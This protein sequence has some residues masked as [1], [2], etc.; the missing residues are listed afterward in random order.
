MPALPPVPGVIKLRLHYDVG[1]DANAISLLHWRYTGAA[2]SGAD[3]NTFCTAVNAL[4]AAEWPLYLQADNLYLGIDATDL[5]SATS[6]SGAAGTS[7]AGT[8][9]GSLLGAGTAVLISYPISRR[10]RGG[11]PRQYLPFGSADDL[12]TRNVWGSASVT[13]FHTGWAAILAAIAAAGPI[14]AAV[15]VTQ[16]VVSYYGPPNRTVTGS[17]GRVRTLSTTR[18]TPIVDDISSFSVSA[19]VA[20]QRRRN[21]QK[22]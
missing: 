20:S 21:L 16:C 8:R 11:K 17:T 10:Y 22:T 6:A 9:S 7:V 3:M 15:L 14:G 5:T 18:A 4:T 2:P 19:K 13:D 1:T 12:N